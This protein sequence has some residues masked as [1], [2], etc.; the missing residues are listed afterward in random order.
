MINSI[1]LS[2]DSKLLELVME[3]VVKTYSSN[4]GVI[5]ME[6]NG[7]VIGI[8]ME[9]L[10]WMSPLCGGK[11]I[12]LNEEEV[13]SFIACLLKQGADYTHVFCKSDP[14]P[15]ECPIE[16]AR[17]F[18]EC[19]VD[20]GCDINMESPGAKCTIFFTSLTSLPV[21]DRMARAKCLIEHGADVNTQESVFGNTAINMLIYNENFNGAQDLMDFVENKK[22]CS[23]FR[24]DIKDTNGNTHLIS[25]VKICSPKS[26]RFTEFL[27]SKMKK[28]DLDIPDKNGF[29]AL[30][31]AI[32]LGQLDKVK[33]LVKAGAKFSYGNSISELFSLAMDNAE[34]IEKNIREM[35][36]DAH[37]NFTANS[38]SERFFAPTTDETVLAKCMIGQ[39]EVQKYL[40][41][42]KHI[43]KGLLI[44]LYSLTGDI[45]KLQSFVQQNKDAKE[46]VNELSDKS[47]LSALHVA[48][49]FGRIE[50][51]KYLITELGA[52]ICCLSKNSTTPM[53]VACEN[54]KFFVACELFFM[55]ERSA[56]DNAIIQKLGKTLKIDEPSYEK[57]EQQFIIIKAFLKYKEDIIIGINDDGSV[58]VTCKKLDKYGEISESLLYLD[59]YDQCQMDDK[60]GVITIG[61]SNK[62]VVQSQNC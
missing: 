46:H 43:S 57:I 4:G 7:G 25:A 8:E 49:K 28:S 18:I 23:Q 31:W 58:L 21:T 59:F 22:S 45:K 1:V 48:A 13:R 6:L 24:H 33:M 40:I 61:I 52:D 14:L 30:H 9:L 39:G 44:R 47:G 56:Y 35:S 60:T 29:T 62:S 5:E 15:M 26:N 10:D 36:I 20:A 19:I 53:Q 38:N 55:M 42:E 11:N 3:S 12:L 37:R 17:M 2:K 16:C 51:C 50:M 32:K 41:D 34:V 54:S 27:L